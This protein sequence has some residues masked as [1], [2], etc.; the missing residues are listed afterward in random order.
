MLKAIIKLSKK[1][2]Y[3]SRG[4]SKAFAVP[5]V[6]AEEVS[7]DVRTSW[8]GRSSPGSTTTQEA[9]T[10]TSVTGKRITPASLKIF[11]NCTGQTPRARS[12]CSFVPMP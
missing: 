5:N 4:G 8:Y 12:K 3:Q 9:W 7:V 2:F 1:T 10:S 6:I 11:L